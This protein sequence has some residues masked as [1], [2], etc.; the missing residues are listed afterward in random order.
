[1]TRQDGHAPASRPADVVLTG[2]VFWDLVMTGMPRLP[3]NGEEIRVE[4]MATA[5]GGVANLAIA[6]ARLGLST[7]LVTEVG[8]DMAGRFCWSTLA[9][10]GVDLSASRIREGWTTPV[11]VSMTHDGDRRMTTHQ[12]PSPAPRTGP[13]T[14]GIASLP[15]PRAALI[16]LAQLHCAERISAGPNCA[17]PDSDEPDSDEQDVGTGTLT[18][19]VRRAHAA[20]TIVIADIGFDETGRWNRDVLDG[21]KHCDVFTPNATEAMGFTGTTSARDAARV[22]AARVPL[23]VVT[24]GLEGAWAIDPETGAEIHAASVPVPPPQVADATGAGDVFGAALAWG[25]LAGWPLG[26]RL[27]LACLC[28][29]LAVR[30]L[31]GSM[32]APGWA[33]IGDWWRR[34]PAGDSELR[35]RFAFLE[36]CE[37]D[38]PSHRPAPTSIPWNLPA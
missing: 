3:G 15:F 26:R 21:L 12:T 10:E 36:K 6:A 38:G 35:R 27:D 13:Q 11:T 23:A 9:Q 8:H 2:T 31:T 4:R 7:T 30:G 20:G 34:L 32:G 37:L 16:D 22:L 25:T 28:S 1:M 5:P 18:D 14:G 33:E 24:D 17:E 19:W 29:S